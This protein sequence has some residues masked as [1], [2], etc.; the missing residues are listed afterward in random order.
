MRWALGRGVGGRVSCR[1]LC[2]EK[3]VYCGDPANVPCSC[4]RLSKQGGCPCSPRRPAAL[5]VPRLQ[6]PLSGLWIPT[7]PARE[8]PLQADEPAHD[9]WGQG[10]LGLWMRFVSLL[11]AS[12]L[13]PQ[14]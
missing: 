5:P 3:E 8:L 11:E 12:H 14:S 1:L 6:T 13:G 10:R 2:A 9:S 7:S 4:L